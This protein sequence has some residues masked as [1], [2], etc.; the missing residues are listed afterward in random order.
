ML[1][2]NE[3]RQA[4][5]KS[6]GNYH[7]GCSRFLARRIPSSLNIV[8]SNSWA[9]SL[10][11]LVWSESKSRELASTEGTNGLI[12]GDIGSSG[13]EIGATLVF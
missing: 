12:S 13:G 9:S 1:T 10:V 6:D 4:H 2:S 5:V 11:G 3:Y 7:L 8:L